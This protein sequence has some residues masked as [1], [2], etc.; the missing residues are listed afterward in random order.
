MSLITKHSSIRHPGI[1][2]PSEP[3]L[4]FKYT[5]L[6]K[7]E[8]LIHKAAIYIIKYLEIDQVYMTRRIYKSL[9]AQPISFLGSR[10]TLR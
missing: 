3:S 4:G 7:T 1:V 8:L 10:G 5:F 2:E 9:V 6:Y